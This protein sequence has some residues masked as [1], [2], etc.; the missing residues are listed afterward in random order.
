[1]TQSL[2]VVM[3]GASGAVGGEVVAAL[4]TLPAITRVS[5]LGRRSVPA[6]DG[7]RIEQHLVDVLDAESYRSRLAGHDCAICTLG[8]AQPSKMSR[9]EFV[10]IDKDAVVAFAAECKKAGVRHFELLGAAGANA[11]SPSLYLRTKGELVEALKE[12]KFERLSVFQ[13]SMILT[14]A[15]RFGLSQALILTF[16]PLLSHAM[17]GPLDKYRG[18]KVETLGMAMAC[19]LLTSGTGVEILHWRQFVQLTRHAELTAE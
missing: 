11:R 1:M 12:M 17:P 9:E 3:T 8:V 7:A 4:K 6:H 13:P 18:I 14:P 19:N 16:W 10:R 5:L 2:S 15:N